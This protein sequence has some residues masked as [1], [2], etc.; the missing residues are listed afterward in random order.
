MSFLHRVKTISAALS[1]LIFG[2][3]F[4]TRSLRTFFKYCLW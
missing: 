1:L 2:Q 3:H 4:K